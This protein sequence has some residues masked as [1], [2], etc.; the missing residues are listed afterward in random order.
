MDDG[1]ATHIGVSNFSLRQVGWAPR[2]GGGGQAPSVRGSEA[3]GTA[4]LA[5]AWPLTVLLLL[6]PNHPTPP[7]CCERRSRRC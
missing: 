6:C 4:L 2:G 3:L 7:P 5:P 1:L